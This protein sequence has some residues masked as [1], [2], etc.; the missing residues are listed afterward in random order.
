[1]KLRG[2]YGIIIMKYN[3]VI[4]LRFSE[5]KD[6]DN[7]EMNTNTA[8]KG[9]FVRIEMKDKKI[10][11][12]FKRFFDIFV[13]LLA[14]VILLPVFLIASIAIVLE[15][16]GKPF[17]MQ[18]RIGKDGKPFKMYKFRSMCIDAEE[19]LES[20][21]HLNEVDGPVFK[22]NNDPRITKVGAVLRRTSV[23]ELPQL[24]NC[25]LGSMSIVGPRPPLPNEVEQYNEYQKQRLLVKPG[26]T[27]YWQCS[28][29]SGINFD[30]WMNLDMKYIR[31][32]GVIT[33]LKIILKTVPAVINREGAC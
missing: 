5:E 22:I 30:E 25:L 9:E 6:L 21:R 12:F 26:I 4:Y 33:D 13:S 31:E 10:Y 19:M 17:F 2:I 15:D 32:R 23:D 14:I 20:V 27:C 3:G 16:G 28:G 11:S 8:C 1:M 7:T 18:T 24:I 29:R